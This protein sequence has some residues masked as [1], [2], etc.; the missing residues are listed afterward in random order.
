MVCSHGPSQ[1]ANPAA[2]DRR[3]I[4][5]FCQQRKVSN[6][7]VD[8]NYDKFL[9]IGDLQYLLGR[10]ENYVKF[11]D[12]TF[13]RV[14]DIT[15]PAVGNHETYTPYA[16]GYL[17]YFGALA[18]PPLGYYSYGLGAWHLVAV[19]SAL[20]RDHTWSTRLGWTPMTQPNNKWGCRPGDPQY[21]WLQ[22]DLEAHPA[23]CT[24]VYFHHPAYFWAG[25]AGGPKVIT[26][27]GYTS[28]RPL[29]RLLYAKGVDVVLTGHEH[30]YER[31][32]PMDPAGNLDPEHGF[33]EFIVGTGGD[34]L[35]PLP[36]RAAHPLP[37][38]VA[39]ASN[40]AF[41]ILD[42]TLN[43]G[44]YDFEFVPVDGNPGRWVMSKKLG[45]RIFENAA[46]TGEVDSGSGQCH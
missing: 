1:G 39:V 4:R 34:T 14:K 13:G 46:S 42:M 5:G 18:H 41:G 12:P 45:Y 20:C 10:Y 21:R 25:Y 19:N 28:T 8:G 35:Q 3:I 33:T 31:F 23:T 6:L 24:L 9:A 2:N 7:V 17:R 37:E 38:Q 11:Y 40:T 32:K 27:H 15:M 36:D 30:Y 16:A 44:S 26:H 29:Y 22:Q 43:Q